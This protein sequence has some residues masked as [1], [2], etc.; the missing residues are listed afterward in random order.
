MLGQQAMGHIDRLQ[1]ELNDLREQLAWSNRLSQLGVLT[2]ALAHETNNLLVPIGS[3]AQ[4][5]KANPGDERLTQRALD[6]AI[7]GT[8]KVA[9]LIEG[10]VTLAGPVKEEQASSCRV[11][12]VVEEAIACMLPIIKQ[13]G[14]NVISRVEPVHAGMDALAL[15]QVLINLISNACQAMSEMNGK[16]Q[17]VIESIDDKDGLSLRVSDTGP[18]VAESLRDHLFEA[19]V[20]QRTNQSK[21]SDAALCEADVDGLPSKSTGSGLGLS[22][23]KQL[24]EAAGGKITLNKQPQKG[25]SFVIK[26]LHPV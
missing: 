22:I 2:A 1:Q 5:A 9:R 13:H 3:Y 18:G 8:A 19:F 12:E 26:L 14:V 20:T 17:I 23:C 10:V 11:N 7:T 25:A 15:E 24:V 21:Q 4:L 6:A 16:R